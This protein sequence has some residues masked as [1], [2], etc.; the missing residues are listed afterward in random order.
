VLKAM[1]RKHT[2]ESYLRVIERIREA[3]PDI[4]LSGD[5]IV[6]F[7]GEDDS[8]FE[9]TMALCREVEYAQAYSFKYSARP[10]TPAADRTEVDEDVKSERLA[11]LQELLTSHQYAFQ[12]SMIGKILPVLLEK[13]GREAGQMVG[14]SPYLHAVHL[15]AP[16]S[17]VGKIVHA[18]VVGTERNSL[19]GVV[20]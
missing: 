8:D 7:P 11:R 19:S 20:V 5:F 9:D 1:N 17:S 16:A 6:G 18:K 15:D 2:A 14:K 3:R 4:A 10:G 13:P 12:Q